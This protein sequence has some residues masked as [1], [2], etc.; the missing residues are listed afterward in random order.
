VSLKPADVDERIRSG[1][2]WDGMTI[3]A[4]F[5]GRPKIA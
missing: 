5:I 1:E 2:I 3:A 4:W